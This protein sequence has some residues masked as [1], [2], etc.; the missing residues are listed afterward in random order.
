MAISQFV[1]PAK[2]R[3]KGTLEFT[4]IPLNSYSVPFAKE[5]KK[6]GKADLKSIYADMFTIREFETMLYSVR[7]TKQYQD[8]P[9]VYTGPA[10]LYT[11]QEAAAVGMAYALE[12]DDIIFGG[13]RSHG[14]VLAKGLSAI[15]VLP[16][17]ELYSIMKSAFDGAILAPVENANKSG[18]I[19]DL[20]FDFLLYGF[21]SELFGRETGFA[22][23]LGN[24]MHVFFIPFGIYPNNAI[25]GGSA[26]ISAGAAL[27]KKVN[28]KPGIVVCN[29]GDGSLGCGPVWEALNFAAQDQFTQLWGG[30][31]KGGLP[32]IFNFLNNSY[33]MGGQTSGETMAYG[34][35]ARVGVGISPSQ[36]HA[37]RVDGYNPLAVIEAFKRKRKLV[38]KK[39]GPVLLDTITYRIAGH[40]ATDASTYRSKEEI[41][42]W[43]DADSIEAFGA[44]L[45]SA[46]AATKAELETI[47]DDVKN[48]IAKIMKLAI[49]D[50][51]SPRLD[52]NSDPDGIRKYMLSNERREAM[53]EGAPET[54][55]A[56]E[57]NSRVKKIAAKERFHLDADGNEVSKLKQ[58]TVRDA[59]FEPIIKKFYT[60]PTLIAFGEDNRDWGGAFGVYGGLTESLPYHRFFN[61][62]ISESAIVAASVG[63]AMMGGRAIPELMYCDFLGRAGDEV[64]NQL[65]KWQSM[66][67]G[68]L[69]MP[70]VLRV[71]VGAK[72]GAQHAQDWTALTAHIP[73]L[74]VC[75][76]ATPYDAKGLMTSALNGT[77]PVVFFESQK[78][79]DTGEQFRAVPSEDYEIPIGLP[80]VKR[81]G[82]DITILTIGA[83]L[84]AG[85][86]AA[87][88]LAERGISAEVVDA[89]SLVPFDYDIL[90]ESVKKTGRLVLVSDACERGSFAGEIAR[91]ITEFAFDYL[92]APPIVVSAPNAIS[93]C[94][95]LE[96]WYYPQAEW[97]L[98]AIHQ[99]I[100][101]IDAY[102][103][104]MA[105]GTV[106]KIRRAKLGV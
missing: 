16:E 84:Y 60:D 3:A 5:V 81:A 50:K 67:A 99:K 69:K 83:A 33:G 76:P 45:I 72:Y 55:T 23:G 56:M 31:Y 71:S 44:S 53:A 93:P 102:T 25:V 87:D 86:K 27:Y 36:L 28:R 63:Y 101:P 92:D 24:S 64:F 59:I 46:K 79:Y 19:R 47:C 26:G 14:E 95:E 2:I 54:L 65:A 90:I 52:L 78:L 74:K 41:A 75:F 11:G 70:V 94:P 10:H 21:M 13:H 57:D 48:R 58:Y 66:S 40:S 73:G 82:S 9:Y 88:I 29:I 97:I 18:D 104:K 39:Q 42:A 89:R 7:T 61:S 22:K 43:Q 68:V 6:Y 8:I 34:T 103:P 91:N 49:D 105:F 38:E 20:A 85:I 32:V 35:L 51:I 30:E 12:R 15:R 1:D 37:E 77:D 62:P 106:E 98:D 96:S 80:D 17:D 100:T 4:P